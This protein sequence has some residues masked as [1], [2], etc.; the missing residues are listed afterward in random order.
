MAVL[1]YE[2]H[3]VGSEGLSLDAI[4]W[5]R[6]HREMPGLLERTLGLAANQ[7]LERM[8]FILPLGTVVTIPIE[9]Q[10]ATTTT[11]V[12]SLWD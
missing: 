9:S 2:T 8:G 10:P 6:F 4:L 5:R 3:R 11:N 7:H 1:T 12:V